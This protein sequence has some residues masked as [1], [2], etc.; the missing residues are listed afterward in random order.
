MRDPGGNVIHDFSYSNLS[1]WPTEADGGGPSLEVIDMEGNY[2]DPHNWRASI[3]AGGTPG[4]ALSLDADGDGLSDADELLA[5]TDPLNPD[6]DADGALDGE[7]VAAGTDP[8]D[9]SSFFRITQLSRDPGTGHVTA[10]WASVA[11]LS[12]TLQASVDLD[13]DNWVD[14]ATGV[15]ASGPTASAVDPDADSEARRFYRAVLE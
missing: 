14:V 3:F 11:G 10:T 2:N 7:E 5:G 6:S 4:E 8:L 9:A 15:V 12:Y 13:P 1:P